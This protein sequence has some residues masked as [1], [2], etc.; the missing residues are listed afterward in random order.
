MDTHWNRIMFSSFIDPFTHLFILTLFSVSL[1]FMFPVPNSFVTHNNY[2]RN[3]M[4][5]SIFKP[6]EQILSI[7]SVQRTAFE[8]A[9]FWHAS[10]AW[11]GLGLSLQVT[12]CEWGF[13]TGTHIV[14]IRSGKYQVSQKDLGQE[15][16]EEVQRKFLL[17][18]RIRQ[19]F[20]RQGRGEG[21]HSGEDFRMSFPG[22]GKHVS[23]GVG[24]RQAVS[25]KSDGWSWKGGYML[26]GSENEG[27][28]SRL[29]WKWRLQMKAETGPLS[30]FL[31]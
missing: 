20:M 16:T 15:H 11:A 22:G 3:W 29:K 23:D 27:W 12:Q 8:S 30:M 17:T 28:K 13:K 31:S 26:V 25:R 7:G 9:V 21:F 18:E 2:S 5:Y 1:L 19:D 6:N 24:V 4:I 14:T 10:N